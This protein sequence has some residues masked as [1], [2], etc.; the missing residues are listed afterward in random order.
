MKSVS[1][2]S[3]DAPR[4]PRA[5][6]SPAPAVPPNHWQGIG[7][8]PP[9]RAGR[10]RRR[11]GCRPP[12]GWPMGDSRSAGTEGGRTAAAVTNHPRRVASRRTAPQP[13]VHGAR[14]EA[15]VG[16]ARHPLVDR[17][18][19]KGG[20]G[21]SSCHLWA[22][23]TARS[24]GGCGGRPDPPPGRRV[25]PCGFSRA[26]PWWVPHARGPES[27]PGGCVPAG[28]CVTLRHP[29]LCPCKGHPPSSLLTSARAR[30]CPR[31]HGRTHSVL[32]S[33]RAG[34]LPPRSIGPSPRPV[35]T[36][37]CHAGSRHPARCAVASSIVSPF[38]VPTRR[39]TSKTAT[40]A[41]TTEARAGAWAARTRR[42]ARATDT[43]ACAGTGYLHAAHP[44]PPCRRRRPAPARRPR[45]KAVGHRRV[46]SIARAA[47]PPS[48]PLRGSHGARRGTA[49]PPPDCRSPPTLRPSRL[50][51]LGRVPRHRRHRGGLLVRRTVVAFVDIGGRT[52]RHGPAMVVARAPRDVVAKRRH[53]RHGRPERTVA[54]RRQWRGW[55][56]WR[57]PGHN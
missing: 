31:V 8:T 43:A 41:R 9:R 18:R 54:P 30:G 23:P 42:G 38:S 56:G 32:A 46:A 11:A 13:G 15:G 52:R 10:Q 19:T 3:S 44:P 39:G 29:L 2:D 45:T 48:A 12:P 50:P 14:P 25:S 22:S 21:G 57:A 17:W 36:C 26:S 24:E 28:G 37:T 49:A 27:A 20:E 1:R 47:A 16:P 33:L 40:R 7:K 51:R 34:A 35:P 6:L 5:A 53:G 4:P 55:R